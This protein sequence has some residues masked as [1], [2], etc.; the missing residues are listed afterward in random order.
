[1]AALFDTTV[2][3][4]LLRRKPPEDA[5]ELLRAARA[6]VA[7]GSAFFPAVAVAELVIGEGSRDGTA[8]LRSM[9]ARLP[10]AVLP[11]GAAGDAGAMGSFLRVE[12]APIPFSDLLIAATA[13]WLEVPLLTWD[14]DYARAVKA[15]LRPRSEHPGA[16]LLR[17]LRLHPASRSV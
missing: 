5:S 9:L 11:A 3:V 8:R 1:M 4:L 2:G 13:L 17:R 16:E 15:A 12:G 7:S 6:E 10:T 14:G